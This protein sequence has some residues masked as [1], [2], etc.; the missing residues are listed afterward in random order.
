[1][2]KKFSTDRCRSMP[3]KMSIK[4][5]NR[6]KVDRINS[7]VTVALFAGTLMSWPIQF[8]QDLWPL[9]LSIRRSLGIN[10]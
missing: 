8:F 5:K 10:N 3:G 7:R 2:S 6:E 9:L 1:M 4:S